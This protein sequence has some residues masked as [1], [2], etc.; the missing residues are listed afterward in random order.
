MSMN[1]KISLLALLFASS[2]AYATV[3]YHV[4]LSTPE[5]HLGKVSMTLPASGEGSSTV[6][7]PAWRTGKYKILDLANG[8]RHFSATDAQGTPLSWQHTDKASWTIDNPTQG[9]IKVSYTVY[10]NQLGL[11]SRH[12]DDSHAYLDATGVFMYDPKRRDEDISVTLTV[13]SQWKSYAGME[14]KGEH[15]FVAENYDVLVDSPIETGI[16]ELFEFEE[17]G[18]DYQLV[19]WGEGNYNAP[20]MAKDLQQMVGASQNIWQG[21][22]F[23]NY[24]F[25]VHATTDARGATEHL[26]ST[27]IQRKRFS[28]APRKQYLSFLKTAAHE[29]VHTWNVKAYRPEGVAEYDYQRENYTDLLWISEGSTSY[30]QS[31]LLLQA[32]LITHKEFFEDLARRIDSHTKKPGRHVQSVAESSH[33]SWIAMPGDFAHNHSVS[34]YSEGFIAS[35]AF[36]FQ[37]LS[38]SRMKAGYSELHR[39]LYKQHRLPKPFNANDIKSIAQSLTGK[40]YTQW[41]HKN[42]ESPLAVDF[43]ALLDKAGLELVYPNKSKEIADTGFVSVDNHGLVTL[44]RVLKDSAAWQAGLTTGDQIV[45]I[46]GLKV[47]Q[48]TL[49]TRLAQYQPGQELTLSL[50]RRDRLIDKS[51]TLAAKMNKNPVIRPQKKVSRSQKAFFKA[52]LGVKFPKA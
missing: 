43:D 12:I 3:D 42:V 20:Q 18:K 23:D 24:V 7:M 14:R 16:S 34:I 31:Q 2:Q 30:F 40:D 27:V 47:N 1:K 8:V 46:N 21:Y 41:W 38:D 17:D 48:S 10:A 33:E 36:D 11:R 26:N 28:F 13:P 51:L 25:M 22:P 44:T 52:W 6:M 35:L 19:I 15:H 50:F 32:G 45:A 39:E 9:E 49:K 29:F 37:L 4:D 5:H